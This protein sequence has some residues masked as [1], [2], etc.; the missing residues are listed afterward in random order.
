MDRMDW[1]WLLS[2]DFVRGFALFICH[3]D[4]EWILNWNYSKVFGCNQC[5][6]HFW[7]R[8]TP[9]CSQESSWIS[10]LQNPTIYLKIYCLLLISN[11]WHKPAIHFSSIYWDLFHIGLHLWG[12]SFI[13]FDLLNSI[14]QLTSFLCQNRLTLDF[15]FLILNPLFCLLI[16]N[17]FV[18]R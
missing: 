2:N 13:A 9:G 8:L 1:I 6:Q 10:F 5:H 3:T 14:L 11:S 17:L 18:W 15:D 4:S 16:L 12:R 7:S